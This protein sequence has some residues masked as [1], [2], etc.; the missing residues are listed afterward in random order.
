MCR[1]QGGR[2]SFAGDQLQHVANTPCFCFFP[3]HQ[4]A[5]M[6]YIGCTIAP[7]GTCESCQ[8]SWRARIYLAPTSCWVL[9][10]KVS[11]RAC[12]PSCKAFCLGPEKGECQKRRHQTNE[13]H[14][15]AHHRQQFH[16]VLLPRVVFALHSN[17]DKL[18]RDRSSW[19]QFK[20][21]RWFALTG[22]CKHARSR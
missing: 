17:L 15:P 22:L 4:G 2:A 3:V 6:A 11:L 20:P 5:A 7:R 14:R 1:N 21:K 10:V 13:Q 19:R 8:H 12:K 16:Q 9:L 18:K